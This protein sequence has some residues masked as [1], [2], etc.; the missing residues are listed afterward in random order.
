M[1]LHLC[2]SLVA[3][4]PPQHGLALAQVEARGTERGSLYILPNFQ[5]KGWS[6]IT[7][8]LQWTFSILRFMRRKC[9]SSS[10]TDS[11]YTIVNIIQLITNKNIDNSLT[12]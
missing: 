9:Q 4:P 8:Y 10:S 1:R 3:G 2:V 11:T 7:R 6:L 5:I 12:T